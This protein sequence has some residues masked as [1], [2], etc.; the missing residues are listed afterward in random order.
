MVRPTEF[1]DLATTSVTVQ[2]E[3]LERAKSMDINISKVLRKALAEEVGETP[4]KLQK[5]LEKFKGLPRHIVNQARNNV[6][7]KKSNAPLT[8]EWLNGMFGASFSAEDINALVPI[9]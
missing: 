3:L 2:R 4:K 8:A 9:F 5:H 7:K 1:L 6:I